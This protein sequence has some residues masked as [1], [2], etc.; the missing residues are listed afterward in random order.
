MTGQSCSQDLLVLVAD[1]DMREVTLGMLGRS[2][3]V[4][5]RRLDFDV[6]RHPQR[7]GGCRNALGTWFSG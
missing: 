7:D 1:A 6:Q 4:A 5:P 2:D 3:P